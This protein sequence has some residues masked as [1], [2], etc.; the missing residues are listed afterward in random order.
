MQ[1]MFNIYEIVYHRPSRTL[2]DFEMQYCN[3]DYLITCAEKP[4]FPTMSR[5]KPTS[6]ISCPP[7]YRT[8]GS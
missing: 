5:T 3:W 6:G 8:E 4:T 2:F 1:K 7:T